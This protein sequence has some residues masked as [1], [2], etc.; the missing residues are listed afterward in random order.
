MTPQP[1]DWLKRYGC[2]LAI[3]ISLG[4]WLVIILVVRALL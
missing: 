3:F 4:M 1:D 2:V